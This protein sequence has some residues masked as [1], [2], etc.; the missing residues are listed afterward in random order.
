LFAGKKKYTAKDH[1]CEFLEA[2]EKGQY[3]CG[4]YLKAS[5]GAK[6]AM[7]VAMGMGM[8][9]SSSLFNLERE[10]MMRKLSHLSSFSPSPEGSSTQD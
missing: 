1:E 3:R 9:C 4:L 6:A 5:F 2:N 8:G 7:E 10:E